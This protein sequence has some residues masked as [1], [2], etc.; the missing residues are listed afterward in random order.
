MKASK[1]KD[2]LLLWT[3]MQ[4]LVAITI[5]CRHTAWL[6]LVSKSEPPDEWL[7]QMPTILH[8]WDSLHTSMDQVHT[9]DLGDVCTRW[10]AKASH[11]NQNCRNINRALMEKQEAP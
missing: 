8:G 6:V 2:Y 3:R 1:S 7:S 9:F 11:T 5:V 10:I 4:D